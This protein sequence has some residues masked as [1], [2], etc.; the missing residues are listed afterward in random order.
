VRTTV[1]RLLVSF[2]GADPTRETEKVLNAL[3]ADDLRVLRAD[4]VLGA[5]NPRGESIGAVAQK[6]AAATLHVEAENMSALLDRADLAVGAAGVSALE[7][8]VKGV[9]SLLVVVATNQIRIAQALAS[10]GAAVLLGRSEEVSSADIADALR[11]L[12]ARPTRLAALSQAAAAVCDG[13]GVRRVADAMLGS[14][15]LA[16]KRTG[17]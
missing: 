8:C 3:L 14:G 5:A 13:S 11:E 6:L 12:L 7:R 10:R 15:A 17:L 2:G 4:I 9:P 1:E 16:E